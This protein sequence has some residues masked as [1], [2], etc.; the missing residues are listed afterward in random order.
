MSSVDAAP[1]LHSHVTGF[2]DSGTPKPAR[3]S[4]SHLFTS[5][6][7]HPAAADALDFKTALSS[8]PISLRA[9]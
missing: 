4:T 1:V 2:A 7:V 8:A 9:S 3:S 6:R 5:A